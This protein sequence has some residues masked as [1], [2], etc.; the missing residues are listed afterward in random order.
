[1]RRV[2]KA[3]TVLV[4]GSFLTL[5]ACSGGSSDADTARDTSDAAPNYSA[6]E[7]L[8]ADYARSDVWRVFDDPTNPTTSEVFDDPDILQCAIDLVAG[9]Q[10]T[11]QEL[12]GL[13]AIGTDMTKFDYGSD[14]FRITQEIAYPIGLC[15][16]S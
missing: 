16:R 4:V 2:G 1:M 13:I 7:Q 15:T 8:A 11:D 3:A 5:G 10:L 6:R 9:S 14:A 12:E